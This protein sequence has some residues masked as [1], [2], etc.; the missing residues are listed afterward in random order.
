MYLPEVVT[1]AELPVEMNGFKTQQHRWAKG[2][3]QTC[4]KILPVLW[5]SDLPLKIKLEGTIHLTSNLAYLP[6]LLLCFLLNPHLMGGF[7]PTWMWTLSVD[8]P[9][10]LVASLSIILFYICAQKELHRD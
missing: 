6:L 1:A 5:K 3:V 7:R 2:S 9:I 10:F 8:V 4:K